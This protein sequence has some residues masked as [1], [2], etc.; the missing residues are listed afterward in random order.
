MPPAETKKY[1]GLLE[2]MRNGTEVRIPRGGSSNG[3]NINIQNFGNSSVNARELSDGEIL[4]LIDESRRNAINTT[5]NQLNDPNSRIS[6]SLA[7]N[8]KLRRRR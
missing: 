1:R 2:A 4:I 7:R 8:T 6:R 3:T 5:A